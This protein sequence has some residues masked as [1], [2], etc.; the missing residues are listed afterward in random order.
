MMLSVR[1]HN[2]V[3]QSAEWKSK[4]SPQARKTRN[5]RS[6]IKTMLITSFDSKGINHPEGIRSTWPNRH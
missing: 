4:N 2:Q 3:C 5:V 1:S 6:K